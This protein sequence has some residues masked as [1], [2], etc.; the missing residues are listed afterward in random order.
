M[1]GSQNEGVRD[2]LDVLWGP[3]GPGMWAVVGVTIC[4]DVVGPP[5]GTPGVWLPAVVWFAEKVCGCRT[6]EGINPGV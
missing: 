6:W 3:M 5:R 4:P 2:K 1:C